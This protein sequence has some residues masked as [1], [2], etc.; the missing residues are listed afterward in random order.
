[1]TLDE[2]ITALKTLLLA[3]AEKHEQIAEYQRKVAERLPST[4]SL[5]MSHIDEVLTRFITKTKADADK[6]KA[7]LDAATAKAT[8]TQAALDAA[9]AQ[10]EAEKPRVLSEE[11]AKTLE[12]LA[13][14][15][16]P[17]PAE[18]A[19]VVEAAPTEVAPA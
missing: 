2:E 19:P 5:I 17:V 11:N 14:E 12:T 13:P 6:A 7:D 3:S 9:N 4:E 18:P 10:I 16:E 8:E 1:M 15:P